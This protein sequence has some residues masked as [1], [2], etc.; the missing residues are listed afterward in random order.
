MCDHGSPCRCGIHRSRLA[1]PALRHGAVPPA[2]TFQSS[3]GAN[4]ARATAA[5]ILIICSPANGELTSDSFWTDQARTLR[6]CKTRTILI[7]DDYSISDNVHKRSARLQQDSS[8]N[9]MIRASASAYRST[10]RIGR[11]SEPNTATARFFGRV[12]VSELATD[13]VPLHPMTRRRAND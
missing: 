6:A 4:L 2:P 8:C 10:H 9:A 7:I 12:F 1:A 3:S 5:S 11:K 13:F